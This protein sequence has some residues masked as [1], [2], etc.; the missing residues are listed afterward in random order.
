MADSF[1]SIPS[2]RAER[3]PRI[4]STHEDWISSVAEVVDASPSPCLMRSNLV[5]RRHWKSETIRR[6]GIWKGL[7]SEGWETVRQAQ[8]RADYSTK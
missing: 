2:Q 6:H 5:T 7:E 4:A 1:K 3:G 8:E